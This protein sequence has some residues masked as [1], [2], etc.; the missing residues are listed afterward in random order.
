MERCDAET[1][2]AGTLRDRRLAAR[3]TSEAC[4]L[5]VRHERQRRDR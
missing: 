2:D 1:Y 5:D 3:C 4:V